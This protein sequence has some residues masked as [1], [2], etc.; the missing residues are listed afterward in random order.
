MA[1][2]KQVKRE[3]KPVKQTVKQSKQEVRTVPL[4]LLLGLAVLV[5]VVFLMTQSSQEKQRD[6][7]LSKNPP[8][9][10]TAI[11][12]NIDEDLNNI[13]AKVNSLNLEDFDA[14]DINKLQ[15]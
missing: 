8:A 4:L 1:K 10:G 2:K 6:A 13:D 5:F 3:V 9:A 7:I 14:S 15:Q 12:G 11:T